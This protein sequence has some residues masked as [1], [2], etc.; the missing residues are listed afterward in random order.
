MASAGHFNYIS[1]EN[2][3]QLEELMVLIMLRVARQITGLALKLGSSTFAA[4]RETNALQ[5]QPINYVFLID[6]SSSMN[7]AAVKR[8][9]PAGHALIA[10]QPPTSMFGRAPTWSCNVCDNT[11]RGTVRHPCY[12]AAIVSA[13]DSN[14]VY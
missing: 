3:P 1:I 13:T 6:V 11:I 2:M 7:E 8:E 4:L 12:S 5:S 14:S 9:C 10:I